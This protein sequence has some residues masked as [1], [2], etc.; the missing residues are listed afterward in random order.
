MINN[1]NY[2]QLL[3]DSET[4]DNN[5]NNERSNVIKES[6]PPLV[7]L[8]STTERVRRVLSDLKIEKYLIKNISLGQKVILP[9]L[10]IHDSVMSELTKLN[11]EFFSY[12]R[13]ENLPLKVI[14][15]GLD[16]MDEKLIKDELIS[17]GIK[18]IDVKIISKN[19]KTNTKLNNN[20]YIV[21]IQRA[22]IKLNELRQNHYSLFN[23]IVRWDYKRRS[24][25]KVTQCHNCQLFGHGSMH[26][27]A[28]TSCAFCSGSHKTTECPKP[29]ALRCA[30]CSGPH[31]SSDLNCTSR[32]QYLEIRQ[33]LSAPHRSNHKK[34]VSAVHT[35]MHADPQS[36]SH[37][38]P[39]PTRSIALRTHQSKPADR[40]QPLTSIRIDN[41]ITAARERMSKPAAPTPSNKLFSYEEI[42]SLLNEVLAKLQTCSSRSDQF[43]VITSLAI[44]YIYSSVYVD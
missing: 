35:Q 44:K 40:P 37:F 14:L 30:N 36:L 39:L 2:F 28:R 13:R 38:P 42:T 9:S 34:S 18:C 43:N 6:V 41:G 7:V 5:N 19:I 16:L 26:C 20:I 25:G 27:H 3:A 21:Y 4:V 15:S 24:P 10:D 17:L 1:K 29:D 8:K 11:F 33:K 22:T 32:V 12:A 31:K 23:T